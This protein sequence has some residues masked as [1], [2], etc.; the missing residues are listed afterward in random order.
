MSFKITQQAARQIIQSAQEE[1]MQNL[2][3]LA[4]DIWMKDKLVMQNY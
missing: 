3:V 1:G 4:P 2:E